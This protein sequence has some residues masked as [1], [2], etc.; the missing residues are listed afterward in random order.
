MKI[1]TGKVSAT[2]G[3]MARFN[4]KSGT[5]KMAAMLTKYENCNWGNTCHQD[6][7]LNDDSVASK[8]NRVVALYNIDGED[9][10]IITEYTPRPMTTIM[11]AGEY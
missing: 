3:M 9:I 7:A 2:N 11:L 6:W 5:T 1:N 10:F 8:S 4:T